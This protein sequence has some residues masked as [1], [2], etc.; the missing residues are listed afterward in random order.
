MICSRVKIILLPG[1]GPTIIILMSQFK[2]VS[3][4][5]VVV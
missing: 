5:T 3:G 4:T 1:V 2:D